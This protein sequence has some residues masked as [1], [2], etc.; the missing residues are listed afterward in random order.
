MS[1]HDRRYAARPGAATAVNPTHEVAA[2]AVGR[3][4]RVPPLADQDQP[5]PP[6]FAGDPQWEAIDAAEAA[7]PPLPSD[8]LAAASTARRGAEP[9]AVPPE[10]PAHAI[11]VTGDG[12]REAGPAAAPHEPHDP[13]HIGNHT[14]PHAAPFERTIK[15]GDQHVARH[16]AYNHSV[17]SDRA[18][19]NVI[20]RPGAVSHGHGVFQVTDTKYAD[21]TTIENATV[22]YTYTARGNVNIAA[23]F[24][25]IHKNELYSINYNAPHLSARE[26]HEIAKEKAQGRKSRLALDAA[27]PRKLLIDGHEK[28]CVLSWNGTNSSA[29]LPV[30]QIKGNRQQILADVARTARK[31]DPALKLSPS[32]PYIIRDDHVGLPDD[33]HPG[34]RGR[35]LGP[36]FRTGD[37]V[38]D[39][40]LK[41]DHDSSKPV[42]GADGRPEDKKELRRFV[43]ICMNL[44]AGSTP[45]VAVDI[46]L[47][48]DTFFAFNDA[49]FHREVAVYESGAERSRRRQMWVFGHLG[50]QK[51]GSGP[52]A[53][54]MVPD[55]AR[56]GWVPL[57]VL[58]LP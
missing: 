5:R 26:K 40:L 27:M 54:E 7:A 1:M 18:S 28:W 37:N 55:H 14:N 48:G 41:D 50:K 35:V 42:F 8:A 44:P 2:P 10:P 36:R 46:A 52:D 6:L 16:D 33:R 53:H 30:D 45:P 32:T 31:E 38:H 23:P 20:G 57:R 3:T 29:W 15:R 21:G 49:K 13:L 47:A 39:Y 58:R 51:G 56:A 17:H 34:D 22:R 24:D 9:G 43:S 25:V 12:E 4:T 11:E 19:A